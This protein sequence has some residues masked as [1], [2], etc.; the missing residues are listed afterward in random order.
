MLSQLYLFSC[1]HV[2]IFT[3]TAVYMF[4]CTDL[5]NSIVNR[6]VYKPL[7]ENSISSHPPSLSVDTSKYTHSMYMYL[8]YKSIEWPSSFR[9]NIFF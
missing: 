2:N 1:P 3:C 9:R 7:S 5:R 6:C 8:F 4:I